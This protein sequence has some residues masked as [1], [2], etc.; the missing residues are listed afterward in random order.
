[1][2]VLA[3]YA[4]VFVFGA[5]VGSFLNVCIY[6]LPKD[7]SVVWPGSHCQ[8]CKK[9]I[10]WHDNVPVL[11]YFLLGGKC[12]ACKTKFS[13]QYAVIE[14]VT[15]LI[16]V[17]FMAAFGFSIKTGVFLAFTLALLVVSAIDW[18]H[19]II[20]DEISLPGIILGLALSSVFPEMHGAHFWFYGL[21][22]SAFGAIAG[23][24]FLYV[25]GTAAE[26]ILKK[27]AMGGGDVKLLAMIG[28]FIGWPGVLWTIFVS[29]LVGSIVGLVALVKSGDRYIPYGPFLALAA[30]LY[31]FFGDPV[32][33]WYLNLIGANL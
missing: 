21:R 13:F 10:A 23:G 4:A 26:K 32:I 5:M 16:F 31:V 12:R 29:S 24:G 19:R 15:G 17:G 14:F 33:A 18:E 3:V 25:L 7:E 27:E 9:P 28:T 1:V 22:E 11:S 2:P 8:A 6:R 20:P 30:V